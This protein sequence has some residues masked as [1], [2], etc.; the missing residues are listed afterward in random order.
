MEFDP[1][2]ESMYRW[3]SG[4]VVPRPVAWV[5]SDGPAG[6]NLAPYSF[7]N[8]LCVAPPVLAFAPGQTPDGGQK[9]T[10]RNAQE[11]GSFVVNLVTVDLAEAMVATAA[12]GDGDE[13]DLADVTAAPAT[14]VD[15][16]RVV[17]A[18]ISFECRLHD[19]LELGSNTATFGRVVHFHA[20]ESV[21]TPD[22]KMD[23]EQFDAL[24][25]LAADGYCTT[26][27]RFTLSRPD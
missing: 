13:F 16:P 14:E 24:G 6:R 25:R 27:D 18:P 8:V 11:T 2:S 10:L 17:E 22:G 19:T 12:T 1:E 4:A 3:L 20:D 7:F 15:A 9:D 5:S 23:T 21:L 26:R